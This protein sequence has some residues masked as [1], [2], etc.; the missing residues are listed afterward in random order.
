MSERIYLSPPSQS[1]AEEAAVVRA[2]QSN[3]IA[4]LGPEVDAF[5]AELA[6]VSG[7]GHAVA[8]SSGTAAIHLA[9]LA[10]GV[11]PGDLTRT[12]LEFPEGSLHEDI[13]IYIKMPTKTKY[14]VSGGDTT[15][16]GF[17]CSDST[18][19]VFTGAEFI[20]VADG[21]TI[22]PYYFDIPI[23]V[24]LPYKE[25]FLADHNV[26]AEDLSMGYMSDLTGIDT[27]GISGVVIDTTE[28]R[29]YASVAHFST[30]VLFSEAVVTSTEDDGRLIPDGY[31]LE[32][33]FPNP[34][35][36]ET[37]IRYTVSNAAHVTIAVYNILGQ[38][39]T[40]L[41]DTQQLAGTYTIRWNGKDITGLPA[42][43]GIYFYRMKAG[44]TVLTRRMMLI[45]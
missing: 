5:E 27:T 6:A 9:L 28:N 16:A 11:Q 20:V 31:I 38:E 3:W 26:S 30:V 36:P 12:P 45:K 40:R 41:V 19:N 2:I 23:E 17:E 32:Q 39:I 22:S 35:N 4:P 33:N 15:V 8:T 14:A 1:G 10:V 13:T 18:K 21:D 29:V 37:Q 43:T 44:D 24:T 34:F 7:V 25:E 42:G